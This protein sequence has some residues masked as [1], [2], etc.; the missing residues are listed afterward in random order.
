MQTPEDYEDDTTFSLDTKDTSFGISESMSTEWSEKASADERKNTSLELKTSVDMQQAVQK[1]VD[2]ILVVS[3]GELNKQEE[4]RQEE[5][6]QE[7]G[8]QEEGR[9]EEGKQEEE[10]QEEGKE[11][12]GKQEEGKQEEGKQEEG[13]QEEQ[14]KNQKQEPK[15]EQRPEKEEE[16]KEEKQY[17]KSV[18]IS[19]VGKIE[20]DKKDSSYNDSTGI[21]STKKFEGTPPGLFVRNA[22]PLKA[23]KD[24]SLAMMKNP[25][26]ARSK[27]S[28][29]PS[30]GQQLA[31]F[32]LVSSTNVL[33]NEDEETL[34]KANTY[35]KKLFTYATVPKKA[36]YVPSG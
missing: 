34:T 5:G 2:E 15:K 27:L 32:S 22:P 10:K 19:R 17:E 13:K 4:G 25:T 6:K 12:E 21:T 14:I 7:E 29:I 35:E 31:G 20:K 33:V 8:K 11:E 16:K 24:V 9:Q 28:L 23:E 1:F 36:S 3:L 30:R 26:A 18:E